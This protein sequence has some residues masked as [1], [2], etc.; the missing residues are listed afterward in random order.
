M[1]L[2]D[3]EKEKYLH[4]K[5]GSFFRIMLGISHLGNHMLFLGTSFW[6]KT[7]LFG[8]PFIYLTWSSFRNGVCST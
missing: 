4:I 2:S 6:K 3:V 5:M 1:W 7:H 8:F